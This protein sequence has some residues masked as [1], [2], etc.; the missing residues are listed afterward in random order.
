MVI[1]G[2]KRYMHH[3]NFPP[4]SAG[5][6]KR[7]GAPGRR[8]IGHGALAEKALIPALP[9]QDVFPYT[10]RVVSEVLSSAGSTSMAA[11]CGSTLALMDAGVP[12]KNPVAG[13]SVGLV[14]DK[15]NK[16]NY[17]TLVDIAYQEDA[18]GDMDC[19]VA[20]T[21]NGVTVIQMDIKLESVSLKILEE[22]LEKAKKARLSILETILKTIPAS[23]EKISKHAPTVVVVKID[24]SK[25]GDVIG[26][27]GRT[28]NKIIAETG[29]AIDIN[30]EGT[31][32]ITSKDKE[33]CER[34]TK[35]V[36]G[37]VKEA[38][39]GE[40]YEG[41][42]KRLLP[43]GAMVELLPGKEGLVHISKLGVPRGQNISDY[44]NVGDKIKVKVFEIDDQHR[45]NL[46]TEKAAAGHER[47]DRPRFEKR[48]DNKR[49]QRRRY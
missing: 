30:D 43:F 12:I 8:E 34:A 19:K 33:A 29:A 9:S 40:E 31:V 28:I 36:E 21:K 2:T 45:I 26:S 35:F 41:T 24:P 38:K 4:F 49:F 5:E 25:I 46:T 7:L 42:V 15:K 10:V 16:D 20:G 13:I 44:V 22:A 11:T 27:G 47:Q 17:V 23:R 6:V 3:Y 48:K 37:I 1:S 18:Q 32:T 39:V 14:T